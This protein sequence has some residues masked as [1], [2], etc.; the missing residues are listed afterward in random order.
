MPFY[1]VSNGIRTEHV[2]E[3]LENPTGRRLDPT[4]TPFSNK[5]PKVASSPKKWAIEVMSKKMTF[6]EP[7]SKI[8]EAIKMFEKLKIHH[9]PIIKYRKLVGM[10]SDKDL[11]FQDKVKLEY[12]SEVQHYMSKLILV[13]HEETS[14]DYIAHVFIRENINSIPIIDDNDYIVG[15]I[16]HRD[17]LRWIYDY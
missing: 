11:M 3:Y 12:N 10:I 1:F 14:I 13:C 8:S 16:T 2:F 9:I 17:L 7:K 5:E 15:I 4:L 6:L